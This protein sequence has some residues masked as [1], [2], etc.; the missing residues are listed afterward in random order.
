VDNAVSLSLIGN[1]LFDVE[2]GDLLRNE[3]NVQGALNTSSSGATDG[4][5]LSQFVLVEKMDGWET[6]SEQEEGLS[7]DNS[8]ES[9]SGG[10]EAASAADSPSESVPTE[11]EEEDDCNSK[12][13]GTGEC[14]EAP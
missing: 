1:V 3:L 13:D 5:Y 14:E 10:S 12:E 2:G 8:V 9:A 11:V 6:P 7:E 4:F